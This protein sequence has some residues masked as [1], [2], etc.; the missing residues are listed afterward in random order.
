M[1]FSSCKALYCSHH[2]HI[3]YLNSLKILIKRTIGLH[4]AITTCTKTYA[5]GQCKKHNSSSSCFKSQDVTLLLN[6]V[7][8]V[9]KSLWSVSLQSTELNF[10]WNGTKPKHKWSKAVIVKH[11]PGTVHKSGTLIHIS[12]QPH[13]TDEGHIHKNLPYGNLRTILF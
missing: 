11:I 6:T 7:D 2:S 8:V 4:I 13:L 1:I 5:K 9:L 10:S 12:G 3:N